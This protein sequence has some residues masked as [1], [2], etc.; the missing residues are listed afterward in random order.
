MYTS[1]VLAWYRYIDNILIF[2]GLFNYTSFFVSKVFIWDFTDTIISYTTSKQGQGRAQPPRKVLN[3]NMRQRTMGTQNLHASI[4]NCGRSRHLKHRAKCSFTLL[5]QFFLYINF[6][7]D[8]NLKF[9]M[10]HNISSIIFFDLT[11]YKHPDGH[12]YSNLYRKP[13]AWNTIFEASSF[14]PKPLLYSITYG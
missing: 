3:R 14:H 7:N 1:H 12:V 9:T 11:I 2:W 6:K 4:S 5:V 8:F 13:T 10:V